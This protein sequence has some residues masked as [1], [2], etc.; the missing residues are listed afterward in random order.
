MR[1]EAAPAPLSTKVFEREFAD[2][3]ELAVDISFRM[4][5]LAKSASLSSFRS[6]DDT[7]GG[8]RTSVL[9]KALASLRSASRATAAACCI[10]ARFW[11]ARAPFT[12]VLA[13]FVEQTAER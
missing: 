7:V 13:A 9:V 6:A 11:A 12:E 1:C 2:A 8:Q 3:S 4:E 5:M 10:E